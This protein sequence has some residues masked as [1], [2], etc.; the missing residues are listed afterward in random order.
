MTITIQ[1]TIYRLNLN[2]GHS[3]LASRSLQ[4]GASYYCWTACDNDN[5]TLRTV[6][7]VDYYKPEDNEVFV[8]LYGGNNA[9]MLNVQRIVDEANVR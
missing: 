8:T 7:S 4:K 5:P 2:C 3:Q 9:D 6:V 1:P